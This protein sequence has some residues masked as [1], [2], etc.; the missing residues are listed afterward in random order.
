MLMCPLIILCGPA[1]LARRKTLSNNNFLIGQG[2]SKSNEIM[3]IFEAQREITYL[4]IS[5]SNEDPNQP[6]YAQSDQTLRFPP[7]ETLHPWLSKM[8]PMKILIRLREYAG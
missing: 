7:E 3:E 5:V 1:R 4:L 8:R 2:Y 6:A